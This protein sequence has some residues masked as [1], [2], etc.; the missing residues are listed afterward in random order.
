MH[1]QYTRE[2]NMDNREIDWVEKPLHYQSATGLEAY[3]VI[4]SFFFNNYDLAQVFRYTV[5]AGKKF[6]ELEDLQKAQWYLNKAIDKAEGR[7]AESALDDL[8]R[9]LNSG[10]ASS[11]WPSQVEL[12]EAIREL[13]VGRCYGPVL[14]AKELKPNTF[15][16][17]ASGNLVW[18][19]KAEKVYWDEYGDELAEKIIKD[20]ERIQPYNFDCNIFQELDLDTGWPSK[21]ELKQ[22]RIRL[23]FYE[24]FFRPEQETLELDQIAPFKFYVDNTNKLVW[25]QDDYLAV[26]LREGLVADYD[27]YARSFGIDKYEFQELDKSFSREEEIQAAMFMVRDKTIKKFLRDEIEP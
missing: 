19:Q 27:Q 7:L 8:E 5:R 22:A 16:V 9:K 10:E 15:Y 4:E 11:E 3:T 17:D 2:E 26:E 21:A 20:T 6:N 1:L 18:L 23:E 14:T 13:H 24:G 12:S 25:V